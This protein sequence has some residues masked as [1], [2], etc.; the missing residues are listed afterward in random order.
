MNAVTNALVEAL[1][2]N[3]AVIVGFVLGAIG[4]Y[5]YYAEVG[6]ITGSCVITSNPYIS[7]AYGALLG[8]LLVASFKPS[9]RNKDNKQQP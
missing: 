8:A 7:T 5:V 1:R 9:K 4:G 3:V 6:C 2:R